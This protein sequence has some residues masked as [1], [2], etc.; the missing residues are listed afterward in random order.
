MGAPERQLVALLAG[1][2]TVLVEDVDIAPP[3]PRIGEQAPRWQRHEQRPTEIILAVDE[4]DSTRRGDLA[5]DFPGAHC[6]APQ[7][8]AFA[9]A[10]DA[11]E[12]PR[13]WVCLTPGIN[14]PSGFGVIEVNAIS[15][16][17]S[18]QGADSAAEAKREN[19]H[20][21]DRTFRLCYRPWIL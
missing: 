17:H 10:V 12:F 9:I 13:P 4:G 21:A 3:W 16:R 2:L 19:G 20:F 1:R 6:G 11:P 18:L 14:D 5:R 8:K 7:A 15:Q